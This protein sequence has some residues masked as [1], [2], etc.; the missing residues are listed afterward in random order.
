MKTKLLYENDNILIKS[1]RPQYSCD[2]DKYSFFIFKVDDKKVRVE[3]ADTTIT[4]KMAEKLAPMFEK[5]VVRVYAY[6]HSKGYEDGAKAK[7]DEFRN[8]INKFL[9]G[10]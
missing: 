3:F 4:P 2:R 9:Q 1:V 8:K 7:S 5:I 10:E 6:G